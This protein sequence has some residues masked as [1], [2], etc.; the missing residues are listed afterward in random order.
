MYFL[1]SDDFT[2]NIFS[3]FIRNRSTGGIFGFGLNNYFQLGIRDK[4][5]QTVFTPKIT[6]FQNV[7]AIVGELFLNLMSLSINKWIF[8]TDIVLGGQHH[9]LLLTNDDKC[10]AIGRQ[11]YGRLGLGDVNTEDVDIL[12]EIKS[13]SEKNIVH[14]E[15]GECCSFAISAKGNLLTTYKGFGF[16]SKSVLLIN[17]SFIGN[18]YSWGMGSNHQLG[19]G[20]DDDQN[21]PVLL[22]GMQVRDKAVFKVSS[23]G[24]HTLFLVNE[25]A[26]DDLPKMN[27]A[28]WV[29]DW[30]TYIIWMVERQKMTRKYQYNMHVS[31]SASQPLIYFLSF[32]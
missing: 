23:G 12:T 14:L 32:V 13:L 3:T 20:S 27:G 1:K 11:D 31:V 30:L 5:V 15:C 6:P 21:D 29:I 4:T 26:T 28:H 8:E 24:Q 9:T 10:F 19:I 7:K 25:K 18:V 22:T 17:L 16:T 2:L